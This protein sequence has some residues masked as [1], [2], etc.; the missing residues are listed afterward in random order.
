MVDVVAKLCLICS[1]STST[2]WLMVAVPGV[3]RTHM[4]DLQ[5]VTQDTHYE[6]YRAEKL[7]V[8]DALPKADRL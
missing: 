5:E 7:A 1:I 4:Q 6:N 3:S 8:G 2:A